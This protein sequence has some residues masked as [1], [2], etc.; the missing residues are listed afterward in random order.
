MLRLGHRCE[1]RIAVNDHL[2]ALSRDVR[3]SAGV[4]HHPPPVGVDYICKDGH[5]TGILMLPKFYTA[6]RRPRSRCP[7]SGH[8][9][10]ADL[11]AP[12]DCIGRRLDHCPPV[13]GSSVVPAA[14]WLVA[15]LHERDRSGRELLP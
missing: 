7:T 14:G 13:S 4:Q 2:L 6:R 5:G 11:A 9:A 10:S 3:P 1:H 15:E 8:A 12:R